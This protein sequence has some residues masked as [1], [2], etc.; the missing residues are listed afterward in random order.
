MELKGIHH[1]SAMTAQAARNVAF[2]T[3]TMG[4]RLVKKTV[5]QDDVSSYHLFYAD[6]IGNPGTDLTFFDIPHMAG[7]RPGSASISSVA[8]RVPD[9]EALVRWQ[10]RLTELSV[11][12]DEIDERAGRP[13]LGLR[14]FEGQ[15]LLLVADNGEPGVAPGTPWEKSPV[16]SEWAIRGLGPVTLT[17]SAAEKTARTLTDVMGFRSA[18]SYRI[19][20]GPH[21][22]RLVFTTGEGGSGAEV[23]ISER[24]DLQREQPGRGSVHHVAFRVPN[25]EEYALWL[26][27]LEAAGFRTSGPVDRYY[28]RSIYFR[29]PSGIL[30]EL[31]TDGPGFT[32]DEPKEHLG[33]SLALPPFLEPRRAQIEANLRPLQT[34]TG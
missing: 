4:M 25:Q 31:A 34:V 10:E 8:L 26:E 21:S 15:R 19:G 27:H 16:P 7:R 30:F 1:V 33:E 2:Y 3:G 20:T 6:E 14:D 24:P 13:T 9:T 11:E 12:H 23:H 17:V 22:E 18:G 28:F 32:S 29:E 5:N